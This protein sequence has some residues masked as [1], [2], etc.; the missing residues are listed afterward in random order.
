V[1]RDHAYAD[2]KRIWDRDGVDVVLIA[3]DS[4]EYPTKGQVTVIDAEIDPQTNLQVAAKKVAV[5]VSLNG[6][7]VEPTT[8]WEVRTTDATGAE[9]LRRVAADPVFDRTIGFVTM[10]LEDFGG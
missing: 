2:F 5:S 1:L 7:A 10:I 6:L 4:S 3:P 9:V 8:E